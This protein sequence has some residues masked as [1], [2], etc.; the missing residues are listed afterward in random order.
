MTLAEFNRMPF[1]DRRTFVLGNKNLLLKS[2]RYFYNQKVSLFELED[3]LVEVYYLPSRET[4]TNVQAI[5][6][7]DEI[8]DVYV[9]QMNRLHC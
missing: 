5:A 1:E 4:I 2:Y 6:Q 9:E 8:L 3:F 7:D